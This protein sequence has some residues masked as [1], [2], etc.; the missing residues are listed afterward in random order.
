MCTCLEELG[1]EW[2]VEMVAMYTGLQIE[3][4]LFYAYK[5]L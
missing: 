3:G 4:V 1:K 5:T 2:N